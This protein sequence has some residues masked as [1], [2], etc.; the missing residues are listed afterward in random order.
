MRLTLICAS[1]MNVQKETQNDRDQCN[2]T[3]MREINAL[4]FKDMSGSQLV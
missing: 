2:Y 4:S 1:F 3:E